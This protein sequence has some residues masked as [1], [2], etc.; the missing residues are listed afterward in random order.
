ME[1]GTMLP[2]GGRPEGW[3]EIHS[4]KSKC[5]K[6]PSELK[7]RASVNIWLFTT[8]VENF[9]Q[10]F[11]LFCCFFSFF[12]GLCSLWRSEIIFSSTL[13]WCR[14]LDPSAVT[15]PP[16]VLLLSLT[17]P[18]RLSILWRFCFPFCRCDTEIWIFLSVP[19]HTDKSDAVNALVHLVR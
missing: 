2:A 17:L 14:S 12:G 15:S 4:W 6:S 16:A 11:F 10:F 1:L 5:H 19:F 7:W 3:V 13:P 9:F 8:P 18:L